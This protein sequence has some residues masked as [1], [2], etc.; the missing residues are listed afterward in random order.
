ML[1]DSILIS[2]SQGHSLHTAITYEDDVVFVQYKVEDRCER[3]GYIFLL[4]LQIFRENP[5]KGP[6]AHDLFYRVVRC[7]KCVLT[8]FAVRVRRFGG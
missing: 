7:G 6:I 8:N 2:V 3:R 5:A 1:Q 4:P